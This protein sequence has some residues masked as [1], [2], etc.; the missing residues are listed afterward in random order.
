MTKIRITVTLSR[1]ESLSKDIATAS[2]VFG[3][4]SSITE[5]NKVRVTMSRLTDVKSHPSESRSLLNVVMG[6]SCMDSSI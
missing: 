6:K 3:E 4:N 5:N 2:S 1:Y